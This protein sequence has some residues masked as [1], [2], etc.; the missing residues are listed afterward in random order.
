MCLGV[1]DRAVPPP[2][3]LMHQRDMPLAGRPS[4]R[5]SPISPEICHSTRCSPVAASMAV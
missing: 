2:G 5:A 3:W 4:D 1:I